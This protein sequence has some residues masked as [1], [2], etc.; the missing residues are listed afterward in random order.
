MKY[1]VEP[2]LYSIGEPDINSD[3]F[4]SSNYKLSFNILRKALNGLNAWILI[5]DTKGINVWCAAG[6]GTFGTDELVRRINKVKLHKVVNHRRIILPQLGAVGVNAEMVQKQTNFKVYFGPVYAKDIKSYLAAGRRKTSEMRKVK[7]LIIDR[8][9]LTPME[10]IPAMKKFLIF[11]IIVFLFF[12]LQPSG[13]VF[14]NAWLTGMPFLLLGLTSILSGAFITPVLLPF[15]PSRSF[16]IK[17]W[18]TG[19]LSVMLVLWFLGL[20]WQKDIIISIVEYLFFPLA[21]SYL[22]LQFTG[23]T[24]FTNMSGAKKELKI[25]LPVYLISIAISI[26]LLIVYKLHQLDVV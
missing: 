13:I 1:K 16:A 6:K 9:V 11:A 20:S 25:A 12:G 15:I 21:S 22:A 14:K 4:V 17:G 8:L 7:F 5:L 26:L 18:I 19:V 10:I 3:V 23:S 24:T 2:G